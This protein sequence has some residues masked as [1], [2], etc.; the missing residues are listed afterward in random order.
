VK[1]DLKEYLIAF[2][3]LEF[4]LIFCILD[5]L[6][7][8]IFFESVLI[9]MFLIIDLGSRERKFCLLLFFFF[10]LYTL[11]GSVIKANIYFIYLLPSRNYRFT[12]VTNIFIFR[13]RTKI[14][15]V[16]FFYSFAGKVPMMPVHLW[17]RSSRRG[18]NSWSQDSSRCSLKLELMDLFGIQSLCSQ[19]LL[20]FFT[21]LVHTIAVIELYMHFHSNTSK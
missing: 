12:N 4:F 11:L 18:T 8:Y 14:S 7:F 16:R 2:L 20:F 3:F 17:P 10:F 9:P 5:L 21:P 13:I 6:L 19:T 1:K 15:L